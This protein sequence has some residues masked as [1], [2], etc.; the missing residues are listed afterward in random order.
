MLKYRCESP[1]APGSA[2]SCSSRR[3]E[4][5][6]Q[7]PA[8]VPA[9]PAT[10][11][12]VS[13]HAKGIL[14]HINAPPTPTKRSF[15]PQSPVE[16]IRAWQQRRHHPK[17]QEK[18]YLEPYFQ[19]SPSNIFLGDSCIQV[20]RADDVTDIPT[21]A[22]VAVPSS[23]LLSSLRPFSRDG[24]CPFPSYEQTMTLRCSFFFFFLDLLLLKPKGVPAWRGFPSELSS[25]TWCAQRGTGPKP[26]RAGAR[27]VPS[28]VLFYGEL[29]IKPA[30]SSREKAATL[31][32]LFFSSF[33]ITRG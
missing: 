6:R 18:K 3:Q 31:C 24:L 22:V 8:E 32:T 2:S 21:Y 20:S 30:H 10:G 5:P 27:A 1:T 13:P 7:L 14:C 12:H 29:S 26:G 15:H 19:R 4:W 9:L 23:I 17:P 11:W 33:V 28:A 16:G 25:Q